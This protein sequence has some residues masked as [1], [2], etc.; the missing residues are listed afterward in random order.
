VVWIRKNGLK[1]PRKE[2]SLTVA[3]I[4]ENSGADKSGKMWKIP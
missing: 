4:P 2:E 1:K 3:E